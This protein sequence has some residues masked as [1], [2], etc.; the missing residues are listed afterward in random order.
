MM[1]NPQFKGIEMHAV[2]YRTQNLVD[3]HYKQSEGLSY[4]DQEWVFLPMTTAN[5]ICFIKL[6]IYE[7]LL[8]REGQTCDIKVYIKG[9]RQ[10]SQIVG[11][12]I[13][14]IKAFE[15]GLKREFLYFK[16]YRKL[17]ELYSRALVVNYSTKTNLEYLILFDRSLKD[18]DM[19]LYNCVGRE[20]IHK[21]YNFLYIKWWRDNNYK[22]LPAHV[23]LW[24][25]IV[26]IPGK[27]KAQIKKF[28]TFVSTHNK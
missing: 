24:Y 13:D 15:I 1:T 21:R 28:C 25:K 17:L 5:K 16:M 7:Y 6:A 22:K 3:I 26:I 14:E 19:D 23:L 8:G 11:R 2:T 10:L 27:F 18:K 20:K 9:L 12:M 4:T